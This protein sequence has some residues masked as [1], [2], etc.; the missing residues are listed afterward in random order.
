MLGLGVQSASVALSSESH[1]P[2]PLLLLSDPSPMLKPMTPVDLPLPDATLPR[3]LSPGYLRRGSS[4]LAPPVHSTPSSPSLIHISCTCSHQCCDFWISFTLFWPVVL[5]RRVTFII[6]SL[7]S[8]TLSLVLC[9]PRR[10]FWCPF[11][12]YFL[13]DL[14]EH[15]DT[16]EF[17]TTRRS[18]RLVAKVACLFTWI[19]MTTTSHL[20]DM[21]HHLLTTLDMQNVSYTTLDNITNE[22]YPF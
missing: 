19:R 6:F 13:S 21:E 9:P 8:S 22:T 5:W 10:L 18:T 11:Y 2:L 14:T 4:S 3:L 17:T 12:N 16:G 1:F 15:P 7:M 20:Q